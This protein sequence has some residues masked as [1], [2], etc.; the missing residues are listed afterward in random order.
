MRYVLIDLRGNQ[1]G[2]Y[3]SQ[4]KL[5]ED[6]QD[7]L[8]DDLETLR[9]LYVLTYDDEGH[10]VDTA[11]R[12]DEALL[13]AVRGRLATSATTPATNASWPVAGAVDTRSLVGSA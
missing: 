1:R 7:G 8:R 5:L 12:G 10:E 6:L 11:R 9:S 2:S 13:L 3:D 4:D